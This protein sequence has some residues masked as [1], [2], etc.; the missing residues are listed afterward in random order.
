MNKKALVL[1]AII[2]ILIASMIVFT[3]MK[4]LGA[5]FRLSAQAEDNFEQFTAELNDLGAKG[6]V[7]ELRSFTLIIDQDTGIYLFPKDSN[8]I[9]RKIV[10]IPLLSAYINKLYLPR[11]KECALGKA[12]ACLCQEYYVRV[13]DTGTIRKILDIEL[14]CK[15]KYCQELNYDIVAMNA[16]ASQLGEIEYSFDVDV[17]STFESN[18]DFSWLTFFE[19]KPDIQQIDGGYILERHSE[20]MPY[21]IRWGNQDIRR[22]F[23]TLEKNETGISIKESVS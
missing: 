13:N 15:V 18:Y 20:K 1:S 16:K 8:A 23:L 22:R 6:R 21:A 17:P 3:G 2:G 9:E 4:F 12:C 7:G 14:D 10:D 19:S 5:F 11:P